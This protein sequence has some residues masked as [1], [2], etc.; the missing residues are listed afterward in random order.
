MALRL[1]G[2]LPPAAGRGALPD[3]QGGGGTAPCQPPH[4]AGVPKQQGAAL[5]PFRR[6]SALPRIGA[7]GTVGSELPQA[8]GIKEA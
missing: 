8:A 6:E 3:G 5:Y 1:S 2:K 7:A 4:L